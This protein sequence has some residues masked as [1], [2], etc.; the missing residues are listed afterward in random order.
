MYGI[1][2][3]RGAQLCAVARDLA[4]AEGLTWDEEK[5]LGSTRRPAS[6]GAELRI[7]TYAVHSSS[8]RSRDNG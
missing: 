6:S 8:I 4:V 2:V 3:R 5:T 1:E 7:G